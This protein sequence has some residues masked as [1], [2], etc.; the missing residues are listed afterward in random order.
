MKR[1]TYLPQVVLGAAFSWGIVMA[2]AATGA[3]LS[4]SAWLMFTASVLWIVAYDTLYAMVDRDDDLRVGIKSTAILFGNADRAM[5]G[6]LQAS[7]IVILALLGLRLSYGVSYFLGVGNRRRPVRS[8]AAPDP[9]SNRPRIASQLSATMSG[10]VSRCSSGTVV[11]LELPLVLPILRGIVMRRHL[12]FIIVIV[13]WL[14]TTSAVMAGMPW[15]PSLVLLVLVLIGSW[16]LLQRKHSL[17]RNYPL[18]GHFRNI[19]EEMRTQIRQY[20]IESD[21]DGTPFDREQRSLVYQRAKNVVD[22]IPFGTE[23]RVTEVGYEWINHSIAPRPKPAEPSRTKI[24]NSQCTRPYSSSVLNISAMSFGSL[25]AA[26]IRALNRGARTRQLCA[27]HRRR[28][29]VRLPPRRR[30]RHR[31]G[32]RYRLFRLPQRASV[33]STPNAS[34]HARVPMS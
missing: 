30:R 27:R 13:L 22:T 18:T 24:G 26:A 32:N 9:R 20:F 21:T 25:S 14:S 5:I 28:R 8:S 23:R 16:D 12:P 33:A 34:R 11:E 31:L 3:N 1:W 4:D 10:W 29:S 17:Y 15:W 19:A 6:V 2:F 7:T